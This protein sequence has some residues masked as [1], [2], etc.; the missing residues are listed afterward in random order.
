MG[1]R[2]RTTAPAAASAAAER[3]RPLVVDMSNAAGELPISACQ[4]P[5]RSVAGLPS[6]RARCGLDLVEDVDQ[7]VHETR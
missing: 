4:P 1:W 5:L 3:P 7:P 2:A 6:S